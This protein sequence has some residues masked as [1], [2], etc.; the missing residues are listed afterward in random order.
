VALFGDLLIFGDIMEFLF[1][2]AIIYFVGAII[3]YVVT[4]TAPEW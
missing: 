2:P 3:Y 4:G 1:L